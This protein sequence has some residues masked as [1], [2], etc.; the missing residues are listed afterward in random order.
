MDCT[1]DSEKDRKTKNKK[2][3]NKGLQ[4]HLLVYQNIPGRGATDLQ[5]LMLRVPDVESVWQSIWLIMGIPD[6]GTTG[7]ALLY[8]SPDFKFPA[9]EWLSYYELGLGI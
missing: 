9:G 1:T 3:S 6:I 2:L 8:P 4:R 5:Q 7:I